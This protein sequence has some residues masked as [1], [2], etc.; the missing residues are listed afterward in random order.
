MN[1]HFASIVH[2]DRMTEYRRQAHASRLAAAG[3]TPHRAI[4]LGGRVLAIL[5]LTIGLI[6]ALLTPGAI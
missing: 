5:L 2:A 1:D 3:A 4:A 6:V